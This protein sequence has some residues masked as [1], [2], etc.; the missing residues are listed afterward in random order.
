MPPSRPTP[1]NTPTGDGGRRA[2]RRLRHRPTEPLTSTSATTASPRR[3]YAP[4]RELTAEQLGPLLFSSTTTWG[5]I[6]YFRHFLPR[7]LELTAAGAMNDWS[8][9]SFLPHRLLLNRE[10]DTPGQAAAMNRWIAGWWE[11]T[12]ATGPRSARRPRSTTRS[13]KSACP[14]H[15]C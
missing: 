6:G 8:Y 7:V 11:H 5:D 1:R 9:P 14:R 4:L 15:G 2:V 12:L 13:P 10:H 3:R